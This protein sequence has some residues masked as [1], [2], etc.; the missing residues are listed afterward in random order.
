M[1]E[2]TADTDGI[3]PTADRPVRGLRA[4]DRVGNI[5][6]V[7]S[8]GAGG[9]GEVYAGFD[10]TL[11]RKVAVKAIADSRRLSE[12]ARSRFLRE[13]RLLS[14]LDHPNICRVFDFIKSG[15]GG[16]L[17]LELIEGVDLAT[18]IRQ[19]LEPKRQLDV[20]RAVASALA[21]AHGA[22][23]IHR[24]LKPGNVML[25]D[26]GDVKVLDFGLARSVDGVL[27]TGPGTA[28]AS[29]GG[30]PLPK[31][32]ESTVE[33]LHD[34][35]A[36]TLVE[37][38]SPR[39]AEPAEPLSLHT[40]FG[41]IV[42]TPLFMSPE[43]AR[44]EPV[45][46]ASDLYSFG[47]LVQ[48]LVTGRSPY[49]DE[50]PHHE[51]LACA[52]RGETLPM[53][54]ADAD[55]R[56]LV[57][58]LKSLAPASR[59][60]AA[61]ALER[62]DWI[63]DK[64]KR[65]RRRLTVA[66]LLMMAA[67]AGIKYTLD[68]GRERNL[69]VEARQ[70]AEQRRD[71]AETLIGFMLGDLRKRLEPVGR[72][73]ILD[74][75]GEQ[76][77]EY[78]ASVPEDELTDDEL[79]NRSKAL[80]QIG[81]VRIAQGDL[82]AAEAPLRQSLALAEELSARDTS[83]GDRL[84][85]VG[86]SYFWVGYV[87]WLQGDLPGT[88][89]EYNNYLEVSERLVELDPSNLD[90]RQEL[91]Y[92]HTNLGAVYEAQGDLDRALEMIRLSNEIKRT[93]AA[94]DPNN[95]ERER[96]LANGLSW[97]ASTLLSAGLVPES[98]EGF[99]GE[100]EIRQR[101]ARED[102]TNT[103]TSY[104]LSISHGYVGDLSLMSGDIE[105]ALNHQQKAR[106][107]VQDLVAHDPANLDW[108]R[109]LAVSHVSTGE[110]LLEAGRYQPARA[111]L[112]TAIGLLTNLVEIDPSNEDWRRELA[113]AHQNQAAILLAGRAAGA[114]GEAREALFLLDTLKETDLNAQ[115]IGETYILLGRGHELSGRLGEAA[116]AWHRALEI[117][118]PLG[119]A[120]RSPQVLEPWARALLHLGRIEEARPIV[121]SLT[122]TGYAR[123]GFVALCQ[124]QGLPTETEGRETSRPGRNQG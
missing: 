123:P 39:G 26:S 49:A 68:L 44:G 24:D 35:E 97:L 102:P 103:D 13:A 25:A 4:G 115:I 5:R 111:D 122:D 36:E 116:T 23:I 78:F 88:L 104:R 20:A 22:G 46:T 41:E 62:L 107:L 91:A 12:S 85:G 106:M 10:E 96:S 43:Q 92:A 114:V 37:T 16:Y 56:K 54:G 9:M 87:H 80:Y 101:L 66:A 29:E 70:V 109:E 27:G 98:L 50:L 33:T 1:K 90:W 75:V 21:V 28:L 110:A 57:D 118:E 47:L 11:R 105:A 84:F 121:A 8:L 94:A 14:Q 124:E 55:L 120:A 76:A 65:R 69:A 17:V 2:P 58:S 63:L 67:L 60:T 74:A 93:L 72:L 45:S 99:H 73:E 51:I 19:G 113:L 52:R 32:D 31:L 18:A 34:P 38:R 71:Q 61:T 89:A 81:E 119:K 100:L 64:P 48:A 40:A 77:M 82:P 15:E 59:P 108:G 79:L 6:I 42:G 53:T 117:L 7:R 112:E 83:D 86:Q 95:T 3:R 30:A